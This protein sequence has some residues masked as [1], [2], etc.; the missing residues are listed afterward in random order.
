MCLR[1]FSLCCAL[2]ALYAPSSP[3]AEITVDTVLTE[4][5]TEEIHVR[6]AARLTVAMPV[7]TM[8]V[9]RVHL[10]D[11]SSL[12]LV[13]GKMDGRAFLWGDNVIDITGGRLGGVLDQFGGNTTMNVSGGI[14]KGEYRFQHGGT[15]NI[16]IESLLSGGAPR[17]IGDHNLSLRYNVAGDPAYGVSGQGGSVWLS[18]SSFLEDHVHP[19]IEVSPLSVNWSLDAPNKLSADIDGSGAVDVAD[20]NAVRNH[21]GLDWP[22][23]TFP[24]DTLPYDGKININ[25]FNAVRNTFGQS[26]LVSVPEPTSA[27][28]VIM[29]ALPLLRRWRRSFP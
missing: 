29:A 7:D 13:S 26:T 4:S 19:M 11:T 5:V 14:L 24:W 8:G 1:I 10:H 2:C 22:G 15:Q 25:D 6:G 23:S 3:A 9:A 28:L 12:N 18:G 27:T 16:K 17:F 21:F 20:L